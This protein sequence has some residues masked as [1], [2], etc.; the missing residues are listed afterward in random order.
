MHILLLA[1][2]S[3]YEQGTLTCSGSKKKLPAWVV[4]SR[5]NCMGQIRNGG[6]A[7]MYFTTACCLG[8]YLSPDIQRIEKCIENNITVNIGRKK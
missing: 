3:P 5:A 2:N 6:R 7:C 8:C 4:L 1:S